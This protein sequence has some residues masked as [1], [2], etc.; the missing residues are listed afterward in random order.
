MKELGLA[1]VLNPS[2]IFLEERP[3]GVA[4]STVVLAQWKEQDQF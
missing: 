1:E 3:V 2:E 4:G